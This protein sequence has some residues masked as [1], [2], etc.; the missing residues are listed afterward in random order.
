MALNLAHMISK[1]ISIKSSKH[2]WFTNFRP[3]NTN[4]AVF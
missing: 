2:L 4:T 1:V 3:D